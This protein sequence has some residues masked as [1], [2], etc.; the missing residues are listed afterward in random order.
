MFVSAV[1]ASVAPVPPLA[2]ANVPASVSVPDVV[3]GPPLKVKPVVPPEAATDV[4]VPA[5]PPPPVAAIVKLGYVPVTVTFVPAVS[6]T[7]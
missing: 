6:D 3:I 5:P 1:A 2:K 7:T 4:T